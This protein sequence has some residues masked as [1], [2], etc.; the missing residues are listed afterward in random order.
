MNNDNV[1]K[2]KESLENCSKF[3]QKFKD[4]LHPNIDHFKLNSIQNNSNSKRKK[5]FFISNKIKSNLPAI[6]EHKFINYSNDKKEKD[7]YKYKFK[8]SQRKY[9]LNFESISDKKD[10]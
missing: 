2:E 6:K 1:K 8:I 9:L 7:S 4:I 10:A 5:G 3:V